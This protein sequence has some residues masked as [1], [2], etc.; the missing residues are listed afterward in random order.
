MHV[1][2]SSKTHSLMA[3][4]HR[5]QDSEESITGTIGVGTGVA[6]GSLAPPL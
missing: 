2:S 3:C 1:L 5:G 6:G 4:I